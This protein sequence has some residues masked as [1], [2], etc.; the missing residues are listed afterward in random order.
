[1]CVWATKVL[2]DT[3]F[4]LALLRD[5]SVRLKRALMKGLLGLL[6]LAKACKFLSKLLGWGHCQNKDPPPLVHHS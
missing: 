3:N 6:C 1:M 2:Y 5:V 4:P